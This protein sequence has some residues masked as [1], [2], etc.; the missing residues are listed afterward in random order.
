VE[1]M[2][3]GQ[4][5]QPDLKGATGS[6]GISTLL[7]EMAYETFYNGFSFST[8]T[9][10]YYKITGFQTDGFIGYRITNFLN[11]L[12]YKKHIIYL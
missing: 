3:L 12:V 11:I 8:L 4:L 9:P 2:D 6:N 5:D 10:P 1:Y 7:Y